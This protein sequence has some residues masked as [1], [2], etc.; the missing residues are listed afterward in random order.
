MPQVIPSPVFNWAASGS[1]QCTSPAVVGRDIAVTIAN[2]EYFCQ[3]CITPF[4]L[5]IGWGDGMSQTAYSPSGYNHPF[6]L[7]HTYTT[8]PDT[9][10]DITWELYDK[11]GVPM[12]PPN[13]KKNTI[14]VCPNTNVQPVFSWTYRPGPITDTRNPDRYDVTV[15]VTARDLE[16]AAGSHSGMAEIKIEWGGTAPGGTSRGVTIKEVDL[17]DQDS[18][19]SFTFSYA[20]GGYATV[21]VSIDDNAP[22]QG[23]TDVKQ[24][25]LVVSSN[26][27]TCYSGCP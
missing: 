10:F 6:R 18:Q 17:T 14:V 4:R 22:E 2:A 23:Y 11:E 25:T 9:K 8:T 26:A 3:D 21:K 7:T 19:Q 13:P 5:E 24:R 27:V 15:T 20:A 12:A 1:Q 16:Y